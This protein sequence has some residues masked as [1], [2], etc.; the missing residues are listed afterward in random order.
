MGVS[1]WKE[2]KG[3]DRPSRSG[4]SGVKSDCQELLKNGERNGAVVG[5]ACSGL[6]FGGCR[7]QVGFGSCFRNQPWKNDAL[8]RGSGSAE[9]E[10]LVV[11]SV[12]CHV[13]SGHPWWGSSHGVCW[14]KGEAQ[15]GPRGL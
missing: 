3:G 13:P 6:C 10:I 9:L 14:Q 12:I 11:G 4:V 7:E 1:L 2:T 15:H 5:L 8:D